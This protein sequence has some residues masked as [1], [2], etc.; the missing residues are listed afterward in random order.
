MIRDTENVVKVA[1]RNSYTKVARTVVCIESGVKTMDSENRIAI[2][3]IFW[4]QRTYVLARI[5]RTC[6]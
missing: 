6:N 1:I 4:I 3:T 2:G 5:Q